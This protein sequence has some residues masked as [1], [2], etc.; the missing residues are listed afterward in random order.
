MLIRKRKSKL[1]NGHGGMIIQ[2]CEPSLI[3]SEMSKEMLFNLFSFFFSISGV[4]KRSSSLIQALPT[5]NCLWFR[6]VL[7]N[8]LLNIAMKKAR[9]AFSA[10]I[11]V[12]HLDMKKNI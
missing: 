8:V 1:T 5:S 12:I 3:E 11:F 2:L 9:C 10:G 6:N 7:C 4:L